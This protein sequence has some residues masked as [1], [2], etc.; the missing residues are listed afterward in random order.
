MA[1]PVEGK[2][3]ILEVYDGADY[4]PFI[5]ATECGI[6]FTPEV[7]DK[8]TY[9]SGKWNE[10]TTR[11][12]DWDVTLSGAVT[13]EEGWSV[14]Q[15][16]SVDK[17]FTN[18]QIRM[19]FTDSNGL[20]ATFL[21]ETVLKSGS[22]KSPQEGFSTFE[23]GFQGS[24]SY[25]LQTGD[26]SEPPPTVTPL[27]TPSLVLGSI[28]DTSIG[29]SWGAISD[30]DSYT[31]LRSTINNI[32]FAAEVYTGTGTS[33]SNTGLEPD[34]TYYFWL[35]ANGSGLFTNSAYDT[36]NATTDTAPVVDPPETLAAPS[37]TMTADDDD[38]I[39]VGWTTI[40]DAD[41]YE[42]YIGTTPDFGAA[43][44]AYSGTGTSYNATGL[45]AD[46]TYYGWVRAIGDGVAFLD[47]P[48]DTDSATTDPV[49]PSTVTFDTA[50]HLTGGFGDVGSAAGITGVKLVG[51]GNNVH[52]YFNSISPATELP[53]KVTMRVS[54]TPCIAVTYPGN[55]AGQPFRLERLSTYYH[56]T[57]PSVTKTIIDF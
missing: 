2:D 5:C 6:N 1:T 13:I 7:I 18:Y 34:T 20:T 26:G 29:A 23:N 14:F 52:L 42:F 54:G 37:L 51:S 4:V 39:T 19:T 55:Y 9:S 25:I 24:G 43:T 12:M 21:G 50:I 49:D 16:L 31:L 22:I 10:Y 41:S 45:S 48:F 53:L 32:S 47:S 28:T 15:T 38:S 33:Y 8:T 11:R 17:I 40:A 56:G 30:A 27:T 46:T 57:F 35:R 36:D 3:A 44:L